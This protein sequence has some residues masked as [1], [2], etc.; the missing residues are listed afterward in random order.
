MAQPVS[1]KLLKVM[2]RAQRDP[3]TRFLSLAHLLD[4]EMLTRAFHGQREDAAVGVDGVTKDQYGQTL[5]A[6]V[7]NLHERLVAGRY[8]HQPIRRVHIP[9]DQGQTRPIGISCFEDKLVQEALREI[10]EVVYEPLFYDCSYGFR[11]GRRAHDALRTLD[12]AVMTGEMNWVLEA[13][14]RSYFDSLD[15]KLL[16]EMLGQR[17][18]DT[19]LLRLVGKCLHV[20]VLD[21][22]EYHEPEMGTA[23]GSV[24]SPLLGNIYL[25]YVLD[26]WYATDV[27]QR[28]KGRARLIRY[29]DDFLIGFERREDAEAVMCDLRARMAQYGLTLHPDKTRIVPFKRPGP[30]QKSGKGPATFD[31]LGFTAYWRRSRKGSWM[32]AFKTRTSRLRRAVQAVRD[33]CRRHRHESIKVQ[34][35]GLNRRLNGHYNYFGVNGNIRALATLHHQ[36]IHAWHKWLSRR[37]QRSPMTWQ[38]YEEILSS[39]PLSCPAIKVQIWDTTL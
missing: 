10:L 6:N 30:M 13:D 9:K 15:R 31:F 21:G 29:A 38:R 33:F 5:D 14:I 27:A 16:I 20:G 12:H 18:A 39:Y 2:E 17:V 11:P 25:H 3:S 4:E 8:R 24:L 37:G 22:D 32:P 23:Q 19:S 26:E 1:P 36:A 7:R 35:V 34:R 28:L